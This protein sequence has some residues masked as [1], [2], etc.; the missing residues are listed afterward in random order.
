MPANNSNNKISYYTHH[1]LD[2]GTQKR[3]ALQHVVSRKCEIR[4]GY[5]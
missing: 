4:S 5:H 2:V 3:F 1:A